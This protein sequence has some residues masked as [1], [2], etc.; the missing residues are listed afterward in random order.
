MITPIDINLTDHSD[1]FIQSFMLYS[2]LYNSAEGSEK[3]GAVHAHAEAEV[4]MSHMD[5]VYKIT[6][7]LLKKAANNLK[8]GKSDPIY[9]FSSD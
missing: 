3:L 7:E 9:S 2:Q 8:P 5:K 1:N 4:N 6:S